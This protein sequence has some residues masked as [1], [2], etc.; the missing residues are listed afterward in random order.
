MTLAY[1]YSTIKMK[2]IQMKNNAKSHI[3][4]ATQVIGIVNI[5]SAV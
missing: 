1:V 2:I 5:R 3:T 4:H